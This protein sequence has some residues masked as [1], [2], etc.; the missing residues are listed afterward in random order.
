MSK[1]QIINKIRTNNGRKV[2]NHEKQ[3]T[4]ISNQ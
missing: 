1:K 2:H 3:C 4:K